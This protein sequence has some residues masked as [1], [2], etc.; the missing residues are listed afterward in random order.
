[1]SGV[2]CTSNRAA[3]VFV[4]A[5]TATHYSSALRAWQTDS[6]LSCTSVCSC[7]LCFLWP[8][9]RHAAGKPTAT[10]PSVV[11]SDSSGSLAQ[12]VPPQ[13]VRDDSSTAAAAAAADFPHSTDHSGVN[14]S[15]QQP[16]TAVQRKPGALN[17]PL[18]LRVVKVWQI[19]FLATTESIKG[20][21]L[22]ER[23]KRLCL[24]VLALNNTWREPRRHSC[25]RS[26]NCTQPRSQPASAAL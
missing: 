19:W 21:P 4:Q 22:W 2:N 26:H 24:F 10:R 3:T 7:P 9:Q 6:L 18:L 8:L 1:M 15:G 23:C 16:A 25:S 5:L 11:D 20:R 14:G 12:L 13:P 17:W